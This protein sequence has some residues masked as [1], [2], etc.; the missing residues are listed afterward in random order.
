MDREIFERTFREEIEEGGGG[1]EE[2]FLSRRNFPLNRTRR[3]RY[4]R[5]S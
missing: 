1:K 3:V 2:F 4:S 5:A